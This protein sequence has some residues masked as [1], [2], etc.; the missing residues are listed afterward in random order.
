MDWKTGIIVAG[1]FTGTAVSAFARTVKPAASADETGGGGAN[2]RGPAVPKGAC[3]LL[4]V[5]MFLCF[6]VV[7]LFDDCIN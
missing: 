7:P 6:S 3:S 5:H 2:Y 4:C 1:Y